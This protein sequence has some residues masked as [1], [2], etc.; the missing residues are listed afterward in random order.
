MKLNNPSQCQITLTDRARQHL[1]KMTHNQSGVGVLVALEKAGCA[2]YMYRIE[3]VTSQPK[4]CVLIEQNQRLTLFIPH[5]SIP[6]LNGS[7]LDYQM[8]QLETKAVFNNPN[9]TL[10]CGCGDS[11]EL[12]HKE[13]TE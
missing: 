8:N 12:I 13:G 7:Q 5:S 6:R 1:E 2:G 4:D 3:I 10:A 9:V 11:V